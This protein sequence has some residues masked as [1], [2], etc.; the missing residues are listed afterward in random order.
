V[1]TPPILA[2]SPASQVRPYVLTA[3]DWHDNNSVTANP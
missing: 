1:H 2:L 3:K